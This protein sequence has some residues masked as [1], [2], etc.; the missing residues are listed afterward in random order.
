MNS[1]QF[2]HWCANFSTTDNK[3]APL[4]MAIINLTPDSFSDGGRYVTL[5]KALAHARSLIAAGADILDIGGEST[6]PGA[7]PI[8]TEEELDRVL[9]FIEHIQHQSDICLSIDTYK[10]PVM[11]AAV[12]AGAGFINDV[13]G[14]KAPQAFKA[15]LELDV[16]VCLNHSIKTPQTMQLTPEYPAG[17]INEIHDFFAQK[18]KNLTASGFK[19][20]QILLDPGFGFG[21]TCVHNLQLI[22]HFA[23]F[24]THACPLVLGVS[25][26]STVGKLLKLPTSQRLIGSIT[27][28]ILAQLQGL[29]MIR[30]HDVLETKQAL[31]VAQAVIN[32]E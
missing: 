3:N 4:I 12:E 10:A 17:V 11:R 26:K 9:P 15:A 13:Q 24:K 29:S 21:K 6:R 5:D 19:K 22:K 20:H 18:I 2:R 28:T 32:T 1:S 16:P 8:S 23:Q 25:R 30:T 27:L 7:Q 31:R 14:L